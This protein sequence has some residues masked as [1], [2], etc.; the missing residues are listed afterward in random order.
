MLIVNGDGNDAKLGGQSYI[1][2]GVWVYYDGIIE[3][4]HKPT[5]GIKLTNTKRFNCLAC[6]QGK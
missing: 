6:T 4:I 3:I 5:S 1:Y 2:M